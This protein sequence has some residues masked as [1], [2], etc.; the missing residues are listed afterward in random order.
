MVYPV[1]DG[2]GTKWPW[3]RVTL[4]IETTL[5]HYAKLSDSS[6]IWHCWFGD[7]KWNVTSL[8][9]NNC[10]TFSVGDWPNLQ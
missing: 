6:V 7:R 10:Q 3:C 1:L 4:L 2:H 5:Y 9:H 8:C